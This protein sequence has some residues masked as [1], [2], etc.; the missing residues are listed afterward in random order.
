M[1]SFSSVVALLLG[2]FELWLVF[3]MEV[4]HD[5]STLNQLKLFPHIFQSDRS[6]YLLLCAF[7]TFLGLVRISYA[8]S[9]KTVLSWITVIF[10]H[11]AESAFLWNL[12]L[13]PHFNTNRLSLVDLAQEVI[14][15]KH[16]IPSSVLLFLVPGFV[17]FFLLCGP[18]SKG[19]GKKEKTN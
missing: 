18:G 4:L 14:A 13:L 9:G 12:A 7:T 11:V 8:V 16:D 15:R 17:L 5:F 19:K 10:A 3:K 6:V 2:L 1:V